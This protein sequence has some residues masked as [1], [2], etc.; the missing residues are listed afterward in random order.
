[1]TV[2]QD[3]TTENAAPE[4]AA[5]DARIDRSERWRR[6]APL[7]PALI[8]AI[9][10]TQL[11]FLI[12]IAISTLN[13]NPLKPGDKNFLGLGNYT[14]FAGFDNYV[15]VFSDAKLRDAV[16]NTIVLTASVVIISVLLGLLL[17]ILLDRKFPGR[18]LARTL[19]IAPFL[20]MPAAGALLWKHAIYNPD[21][22]LINGTLNGIWQLF[23][24]EQGPTIDWVG[25]HPM[26]AVVAV[27]V[28][29]WTPFMMLIL[30]AGLQSQ[31]NDILEAARLDRASGFQTFRFITLPHMR[32]YIELSILLGSIYV[33]QTFDVIYTIT[34]GG[35]GTSTTNLP[36]AI[37]QQM[38]QEYQYGQ[39]A[40]AGVLVVI[41]SIIIATFSLRLISSLLTEEGRK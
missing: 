10:V 27:L 18:G 11:P 35:P 37:Y 22:G 29:M 14:S 23:G 41:A 4:G 20:V 15:K 33:L 1:M 21:Y 31:S 28:W 7:M 2:T 13:W 3:E 36:I 5:I 40:A 32:Q 26:P 38:F 39:A 24:A 6:R 9:A 17:A 19:L 16:V 12:T 25:S 30:L 34:K 8:F